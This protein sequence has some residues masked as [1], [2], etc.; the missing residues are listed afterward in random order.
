MNPT[1]FA[2]LVSHVIGRQ[3]GRDDSLSIAIICP[4]IT[5]DCFSQY[6]ELKL[7]I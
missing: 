7:P 5:P 6:A 2:H 1:Q 4:T 3:Y